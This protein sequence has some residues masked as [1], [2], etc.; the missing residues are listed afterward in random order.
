MTK[1]VMAIELSWKTCPIAQCEWFT[2]FSTQTGST[3]IAW[4][5]LVWIG[6]DVHFLDTYKDFL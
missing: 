4:F 5:I 2:E 6:K 1:Y 3:L